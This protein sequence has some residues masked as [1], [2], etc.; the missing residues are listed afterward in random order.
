MAT[1]DAVSA[2]NMTCPDRVS[3]RL[4]DKS[5]VRL[6]SPGALYRDLLIIG[7]RVNEGLPGSPGHIRAYD[8]RNGKLRW[9][10]H[11]IPHPG[12]PGYETWP[13]ESWQYNGGAN[14]WP[15]MA[16]DDQRGIV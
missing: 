9:T 5:P 8:V 1:C 6:T 10:F 4:P 16:L 13:K 12:E 15:G 3:L 2:E 7:G 11:T 14:S